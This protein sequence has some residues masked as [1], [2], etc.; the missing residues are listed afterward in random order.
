MRLAAASRLAFAV[1]SV[2]VLGAAFPAQAQLSGGLTVATDYRLRGVSLTDRRGAV[3]GSFAYDHASGAYAGGTVVVHDP[4]A[5]GPRVLG[6]QAYAGVA[7][8]LLGGQ[9]WDVGV[10]RVDMAPRYDRRYSTEYTEAY[11]GLSQGDLS[12]R[13]SLAA[14]YPRKGVETAYI[15]LN[16]AVRPA[17]GWRLTGHV[18]LQ[19]PLGGGP[20]DEERVDVTLAVAR[21]I[22]RAEAQLNWTVQTPRPRPDSTWTRPGLSA[23]LSVYF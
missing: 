5:L 9:G 2:A 19:A 8:R 4:A 17:D 6:Y 21:R 7:G 16:G 18:G 12:G 11:L 14:D 20:K 1:L 23:A 3:S 15:E 22:G 10:S 13:V